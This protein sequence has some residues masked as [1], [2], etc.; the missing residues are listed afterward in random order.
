MN[1]QFPLI[2]SNN[3]VV[4]QILYQHG[5]SIFIALRVSSKS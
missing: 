3:V 5:I 1:E 2:L 4:H